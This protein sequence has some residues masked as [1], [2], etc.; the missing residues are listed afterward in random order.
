[1]NQHWQALL[2]ILPEG[3]TKHLYPCIEDLVLT[4]DF[5]THREKQ[6]QLQRQEVTQF[7]CK[8]LVSIGVNVDL[9]KAWLV[10]YSVD[11]LSSISSSKASAIRHSTK[12]NVKFIYGNDVPFVC[13]CEE[14]MVNAT[15]N[16]QCSVFAQM[17]AALAA[18]KAIIPNYEVV[19]YVAPPP[20][21][22]PK[23]LFNAA[24]TEFS[25]VLLEQLKM[26]RNQKDIAQHLNALGYK[27]KTGKAWSVGTLCLAIRSDDITQALVE[28]FGEVETDVAENPKERFKTTYNKLAKVLQQQLQAQRNQKDITQYL[29]A[30][31]FKTK[32][33]KTWTLNTVNRAI[34]DL[35]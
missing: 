8:W 24:Y 16:Q 21:V 25:K 32:T 11:V 5:L 4:Q 20:R 15:C 23:D 28:H 1:M 29:N 30:Q 7:I 17:S 14:N 19:K 34:R 13:H 35:N 3:A 27:T 12:S 22:N 2:E 26:K 9:A 10:Q 31:G 6:P 18:Q 33:G